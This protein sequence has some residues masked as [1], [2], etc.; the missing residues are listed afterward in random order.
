MKVAENCA[1]EVTSDSRCHLPQRKNQ[2]R[3][4]V[5]ERSSTEETRLRKV[6]KDD[7]AA[8]SPH[9]VAARHRAN[10]PRPGESP[11]ERFSTEMNNWD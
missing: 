11:E 4:G 8:K 7:R 6:L 2:E 9:L 1:R 3:P 5:C 10:P